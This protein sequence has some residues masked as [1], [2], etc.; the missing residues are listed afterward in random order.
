MTP[1]SLTTHLCCAS[2]CPYDGARVALQTQPSRKIQAHPHLLEVP[3]LALAIPICQSDSRRLRR[4]ARWR[5]ACAGAPDSHLPNIHLSTGSHPNTRSFTPAQ[6]DPAS[7]SCRSL[8]PRDRFRGTTL[9][10]I[11]PARPTTARWMGGDS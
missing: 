11:A 9:Y 5:R 10:Y 3:E 6:R 8:A 2:G 4:E 7:A 1:R